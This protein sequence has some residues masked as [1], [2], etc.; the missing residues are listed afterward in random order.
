MLKEKLAGLGDAGGVADA[1]DDILQCAAGGFVIVH[2]VGG[3]E[4]DVGVTR[5]RCELF[6]CAVVFRGIQA[7]GGERETIIIKDCAE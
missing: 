3:D 2:I 5:K 1:G 7:A 4:W 6:Q